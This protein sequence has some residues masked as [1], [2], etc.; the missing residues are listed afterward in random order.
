MKIKTIFSLFLPLLF[1]EAAHAQL[2]RLHIADAGL[3]KY[4]ELSYSPDYDFISTKYVEPKFDA[5][6]VYAFDYA[7]P[8]QFN[9]VDI[10]CGR[11]FY[12]AV[13]ERGKT[14]DVTVSKD[15]NGKVKFVVKSPNK[16]GDAYLAHLTTATSTTAITG[17]GRP[18]DRV[19]AKEALRQLDSTMVIMRKEMKKVKPTALNDFLARLTNAADIHYKLEIL[20]QHRDNR[21][22]Y[23]FGQPEY[24][25][26]AATIKVND[27]IYLYYHL[28][29]RYILQQLK[30][31][32]MEGDDLTGFGLKYISRM[33]TAG[34]T[35]SL[36]KHTLLDRLADFVLYESHPNDVDTFWKTLTDYAGNDTALIHKYSD[37]IA[38]LRA[39][40]KGN[41]AT[42][43][44]FSDSLGVAHSFS[45][46][47]GKVLYVDLWATWCS[48]CQHE[49]PH[50]AKVA[51]HY[52]DNA[53]VQ[54]I[55]ISMDNEADR[56]KWLAQIRR[57]KPAWPQ[58][59]LS[60]AEHAKI[61]KDYG[62]M[63]IPRFILIDADGNLVNADATRPSDPEIYNII[64]SLLK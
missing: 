39:T 12:T 9:W 26:A 6:G 62:V 53:K 16:A 57:E 61:S 10:E 51:A 37:Q 27:P 36:V 21:V 49:I 32:D 60:K 38:S 15:K 45:E 52:K 3:Q 47:K 17:Y 48:P 7:M 31:E 4:T 56:G 1:S 18:E 20:S 50:F 13:I 55:S 33:K 40:K 2:L 35:D 44:T 46:F 22:Y 58:F 28:N 8:G 59:I 63:F 30:K 34:I 14:A 54:L 41:P 29:D 43:E 42:N 19:P 11:G 24:D 64:D 23:K 25:E 5:N